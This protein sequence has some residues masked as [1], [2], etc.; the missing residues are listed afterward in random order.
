MQS[1]QW[2]QS[3]RK[4]GS[5]F[6]KQDESMRPHAWHTVH[7]ICISIQ[8]KQPCLIFVAILLF[9]Q[10]LKITLIPSLSLSSSQYKATRSPKLYEWLHCFFSL[11]FLF[12]QFP[13]LLLL[14]LLTR[15]GFI[16]IDW[17]LYSLSC[18]HSKN[19]QRVHIQMQLSTFLHHANVLLPHQIKHSHYLA[20]SRLLSRSLCSICSTVSSSSD[21]PSGASRLPFG[22]GRS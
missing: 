1:Q 3:Q 12:L 4:Q 7:C 13:F 6:P 20:V 14:L 16:F 11:I 8:I 17:C 18:P 21:L 5:L 2:V 15:M 19:T 9:L 22:G 10:L